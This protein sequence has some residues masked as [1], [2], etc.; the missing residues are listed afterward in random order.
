MHSRRLCAG[1]GR[2]ASLLSVVYDTV[3]GLSRA[4]DIRTH[5]VVNVIEVIRNDSWAP[6]E[7]IGRPAGVTVAELG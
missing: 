5:E 3:S 2:R 7:E 6:T 1:N 4:V